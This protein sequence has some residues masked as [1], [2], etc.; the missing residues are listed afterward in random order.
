M[1]VCSAQ[2]RP[3]GLEA[4][5]GALRVWPLFAMQMRH[6][7]YAIKCILSDQIRNSATVTLWLN[8]HGGSAVPCELFSAELRAPAPF[9]GVCGPFCPARPWCFPATPSREGG[10]DEAFLPGVELT[11]PRSKPLPSP[12]PEGHLGSQ[13][14]AGC[15]CCGKRSRHSRGLGCGGPIEGTLGPPVGGHRDGG[16]ECG[17]RGAAQRWKG[18]PVPPA[19]SPSASCTG[20]ELPTLGR[21]FPGVRPAPSQGILKMGLLRRAGPGMGRS[22]EGGAERVGG[23]LG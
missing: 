2:N 22:E 23:G 1:G 12:C 18:G 11:W 21:S 20:T 15:L 16:G 17:S 19:P 9:W 10:G 8:E 13:L 6:L 5:P 3:P 4:P 7:Q 14:L